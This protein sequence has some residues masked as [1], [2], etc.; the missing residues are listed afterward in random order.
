MSNVTYLSNRALNEMEV[1]RKNFY[2]EVMIYL[3]EQCTC[4]SKYISCVEVDPRIKPGYDAGYVF[5]GPNDIMIAEIRWNRAGRCTDF[6][7]YEDKINDVRVMLAKRRAERARAKSVN[8]SLEQARKR[9]QPFKKGMEELVYAVKRNIK[10]VVAAGAFVAVLA[11][12]MFSM[13]EVLNPDYINDSYRSGYQA[14]SVETHRTNDNSGYWYDYG[15]IAERF[16]AETMDFDSYVYG[17]YKNVGWNQE[18]RI[19]CMN[20]LFRQFNLQGITNYSS[21]LEYCD[22]KGVCKEKDG[23]LVIDTAKFCSVMEE[24]MESLNVVDEFQ[25]DKSMNR[26]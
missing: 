6:L 21:F 25:E 14:V 2:Q 24:Y 22:A 17:T 12:S 1:W 26:M 8:R 3:A 10:E 7:V 5:F 16:D 9:E 13:H 11:T 15:D 23:N 19:D 20:S 18:S 4:N